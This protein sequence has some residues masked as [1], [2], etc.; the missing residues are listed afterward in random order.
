MSE[1]YWKLRAE[2]LEAALREA[3]ELIHDLIDS[4]DGEV[5]RVQ[6]LVRTELAPQ[7]ERNQCDGCARG[8]PIDEHGIHRGEGYDVIVCTADRYAHGDDHE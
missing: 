8:M 3:S 7:P 6:R 4:G 2:R 1:Q 5:D